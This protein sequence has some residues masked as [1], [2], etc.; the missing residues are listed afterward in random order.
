MGNP[1]GTRDPMGTGL[2]TKLNPSWVMGFLAGKFYVH[3]HGFG[4]TKPSGFVP[5]AISQVHQELL[6]AKG[7]NRGLIKRFRGLSKFWI[8]FM[9]ITWT[10]LWE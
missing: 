6:A 10:T 9:G 2:G 1:M 7:Q 8:Y 5:I 4:L 3:G